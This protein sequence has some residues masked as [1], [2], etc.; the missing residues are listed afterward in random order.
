MLGIVMPLFKLTTISIPY[1]SLSSPDW[2]HQ[3]DHLFTKIIQ[4]SEKPQS[5]GCWKQ[6]A[7]QGDGQQ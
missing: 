3:Q 6:V 7:R 2:P 5:I 1:H 4:E